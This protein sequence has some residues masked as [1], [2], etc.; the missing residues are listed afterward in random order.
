MPPQTFRMGLTMAK[1]MK[2]PIVIEAEQ[3][4]L[5]AKPPFADQS[6]CNHGSDGWHVVT[7]HGQAIKIVDGDW[8]IPE[9]DGRGFYPCKP[10]IFDA[11]YD[12]VEESE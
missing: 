8:I 12:L 3:F 6:A 1:Y 2:K 10:D 5:G 4:K 9:P 7:A 11:S